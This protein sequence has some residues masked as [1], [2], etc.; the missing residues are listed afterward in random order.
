MG[1]FD[2]TANFAG[3]VTAYPPALPSDAHLGIIAEHEPV[4]GRLHGQAVN[5]H[6]PADQAV[7]DA[8]RDI[9]D[10]AALEHDAVL[11]LRIADLGAAADRGERPDVGVDD[12][13]VLP[14]D[15]RAADDRALHHRARFDH[16][17]AFDP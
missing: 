4:R 1:T 3:A 17:L 16:H 12:P 11:D 14:D 6:V 9:A 13:R 7:L 15:D 10:H 5:L 2:P 8:V